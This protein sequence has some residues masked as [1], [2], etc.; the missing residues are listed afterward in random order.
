MRFPSVTALTERAWAVALRFPW[1]LAAAALAAAAACVAVGRN[2]ERA[3]QWG[4]IAMTVMLAVPLS[5]GI[6]LAGERRG[7]SRGLALTLQ[8]AGIALL[9]LFYAGWPGPREQWEML[10]YVQLSAALHLLVAVLPFIR[11]PETTA[12]WEY[13]RQLF[14]AFLRAAV[15]SAVLFVGLAIALAALDKLFGVHVPGELYGR[16]WLVIA[17]LGNTWIF[18]AALPNDVTM[19]EG[20]TDYP[21]ALKIFTQYILTPLVG[22]YLVILTAY[23]AKILVT[24]QWPSGWI[25]WLV[26]SVAVSGIL[27]FLLVDPLRRARDEGWIAIYARWLFIG[28]MP[29]AIMLLL[30]LGKRIEPYGLTELRVIALALGVWLFTVAVVYTIRPASGIRLIPLS[31]AAVLA[32]LMA[33]PISATRLSVRSQT[34]R[35]NELLAAVARATP[36]DTT[37]ETR[38][39][40]SGA[41]RYLVERHATRP[42][43]RAFGIPVPAD[44]GLAGRADSIATRLLAGKSIGYLPPDRS[45][46]FYQAQTRPRALPV[47][48]AGW[49]WLVEVSSGDTGTVMVG[50]DSLHYGTDSTRTLLTLTGRGGDTLRFELAAAARAIAVR[51]ARPPVW[52]AEPFLIPAESA[53]FRGVLALES[54]YGADDGKI[55][56]WSAQ[57]LLALR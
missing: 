29:A 1:T 44:T 45:R 10:R 40:L 19:R 35:L 11:G 9:V 47:S 13:N 3:D 18:L 26:G 16:L 4:R 38:Q 48:A 52:T 25:G 28:L 7:W 33:G 31:L 32:V 5:A 49:Q 6:T 15:F 23:L 27:G 17:L 14:L 41:T 30:A 53:R 55:S 20:A 50:G 24:R 12:F 21:R 2:G 46:R 42:L 34:H 43:E 36:R 22:V 54:I 56:S 57:L 37:S 51:P 8:V 39:E